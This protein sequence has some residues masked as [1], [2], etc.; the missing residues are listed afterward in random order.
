[1]S[2]PHITT[3]QASVE[4]HLRHSFFDRSQHYLFMDMNSGKRDRSPAWGSSRGPAIADDPNL[5]KEAW[6]KL[7]RENLKPDIRNIEDTISVALDERG[8]QCVELPMNL[9]CGISV[10]NESGLFEFSGQRVPCPHNLPRAVLLACLAV[11]AVKFRA[12]APNRQ[13]NFRGRRDAGTVGR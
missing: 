6:E 4:F 9:L 12:S 7:T 2:L 10:R 1:M 11:L 8:R 3:Y 13:N 5:A